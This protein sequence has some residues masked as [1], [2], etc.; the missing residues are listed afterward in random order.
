MSYKVNR[1]IGQSVNRSILLLGGTPL[2]L[3][4]NNVQG[5]GAY[6]NGGCIHLQP[7][8]IC[9]KFYMLLMGVFFY[10]FLM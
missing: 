2:S 7:P 8:F 5:L 6:S 1:S 3:S 10:F 9:I 4:P